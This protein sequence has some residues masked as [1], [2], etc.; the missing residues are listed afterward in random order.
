MDGKITGSLGSTVCS[1]LILL[2]KY[3]GYIVA[4][5]T[6]VYVLKFANCCNSS[7]CNFKSSLYYSNILSTKEVLFILYAYPLEVLHTSEYSYGRLIFKW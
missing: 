2:Q 3:Y 1:V 6:S 7:R 4:V 5:F